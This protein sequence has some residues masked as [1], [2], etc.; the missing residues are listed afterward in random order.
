MIIADIAIFPIGINGTE[1]SK[2]VSVA[3]EVIKKSKIKYNLTSMGTQIESESL[4][5]IYEVIQSAQEAIF[6][7][8]IGRVYTI[9]K[10]DDRRDIS[11]KSMEDKINSVNKLLNK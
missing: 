5:V 7:L 2:Y 11:N 6:E 8:G 3:V 4:N 9:I 1:L 10:I